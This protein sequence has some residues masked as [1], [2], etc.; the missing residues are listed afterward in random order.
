MM[1]AG[2][3]GV[4]SNESGGFVTDVFEILEKKLGCGPLLMR[5]TSALTML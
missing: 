3:T 2:V 1:K 5:L 4:G